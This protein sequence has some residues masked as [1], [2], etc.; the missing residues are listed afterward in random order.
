MSTATLDKTPETPGHS[1]RTWWIVGAIV[2]VVIVV[3]AAVA[4]VLTRHDA[5]RAAGPT[6]SP[7]AAQQPTVQPSAQQPSAQ[8]VPPAA[9]TGPAGTP[10]TPA[11]R[12]LPLWPFGSVPDAIAWQREASP[13]GHQPWRLSP[14]LTALAFTANYLGFE[15]VDRSLGTTMR[16]DQAWVRLGWRLPNGADSVAAVVHLARIGEGDNPPW[17]VVG[18]E[19]STLTLDIPVYGARVTSPVTVGG[20]I[21]GVDESLRVQ[22]RGLDSPGVL[23]EVSGSPAGGEKQ[24]WSVRVSFRGSSGAVRTIVVSTASHTGPGISRF[25]I[26]GVRVG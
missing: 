12:F 11:F 5:P 2:A 24:P 13:G 15:T 1:R 17:E 21:T 23:G 20:L 16:G 25:A 3:I 14:D 9:P 18:T 8:P 22:V 6:P 7:P 19:D 26:T 10:T 4:L